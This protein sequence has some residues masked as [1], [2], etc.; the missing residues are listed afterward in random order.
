MKTVMAVVRSQKESP[1]D[2]EACEGYKNQND[3]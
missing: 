1:V 2:G 3:G